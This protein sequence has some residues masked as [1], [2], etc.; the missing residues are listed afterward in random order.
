MYFLTDEERKQLSKGYLPR[1]RQMEIAEELRGWNWHQPPLAPVYDQRLA[2]YEVANSYCS[3]NRDLYLRRIDGIKTRPNAAMIRGKI[4]HDIL[5]RVLVRAKRLIYEKGVGNF[6]EILKQLN[7]PL[8]LGFL[9]EYQDQLQEAE[10]S[11]LKKKAV[12]LAAFENARVAARVQE[13]LVKQPYIAE[14]SLA[15]LAIPVVV[16]QK[17]DGTFFGLSANLSADAY[18]FSEP[19]VLDLKFGRPQK[20]H[21]L[22]TTGY[23]LVMEAIYEYP[24]NLGCLVYAEFKGD[25]LVVK[26]DIHVIDE[27]L[28]QWFIEERDEKMRMV[29]EEMDPG[30]GQCYDSCPYN[31]QCHG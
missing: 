13:I 21:Q 30:F 17:L 12:T 14:D 10:F 25:R 28:R 29:Y 2:L 4:F 11:E 27:E 31:L 23:A 26:K 3:T 19:M 7:A 24:I 20:F 6:Q 9:S 1:S 15:A 5:V 22:T 18:T 8:S 16:E